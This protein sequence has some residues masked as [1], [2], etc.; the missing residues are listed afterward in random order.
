MPQPGVPLA[1]DA[2]V[3]SFDS[4]ANPPDTAAAVLA[5]DDVVA[6]AELFVGVNENDGNAVPLVVLA[7]DNAAAAVDTAVAAAELLAGV[8]ENGEGALVLLA[9]D[10]GA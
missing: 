4:P 3:G 10:T 2:N 6:A 9:L 1:S 7:T 5:T 8:N